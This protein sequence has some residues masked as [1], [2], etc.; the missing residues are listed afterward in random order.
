M[1]NGL[2]ILASQSEPIQHE[3]VELKNEELEKD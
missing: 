2:G 1:A 3:P